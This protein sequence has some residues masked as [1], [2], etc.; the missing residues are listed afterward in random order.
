M[1]RYPVDVSARVSP[2][3]SS[4]IESRVADPDAEQPVTLASVRA[5]IAGLLPPSLDET[6]RLHHFDID[7]SLLDELDALIAEYGGDVLAIDFAES[8][9]SEPLSRVIDAVLG[10]ENRENPPTL[11]AIRDAIASGLPAKLVG[12]GDLEDD[13]DETLL[14]EIEALIRRHGEDALAEQFLRYE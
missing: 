11:G 8:N 4:L 12:D 5:F 7:E 13:E 14:A 6:E 10:D 2:N 1:I 9:A 3:L